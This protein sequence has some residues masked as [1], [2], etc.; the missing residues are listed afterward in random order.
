[1]H[2]HFLV[3]PNFFFTLF[4]NLTGDMESARRTFFSNEVSSFLA[5]ME[6]AC[7]PQPKVLLPTV[8]AA[9]KEECATPLCENET[10][11][12]QES[13]KEGKTDLNMLELS[14]KKSWATKNFS[15]SEVIIESVSVREASSQPTAPQ[16]KEEVQQKLPVGE[17]G[18]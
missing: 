10:S 6:S 13:R 16:A 8:S 7:S 14:S 17:K 15:R 9:T 4:G 2:L 5:D 11:I 3:N 12:M 1:M 18:W